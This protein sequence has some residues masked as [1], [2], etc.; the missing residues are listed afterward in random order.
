MANAT[1]VGVILLAAVLLVGVEYLA[2]ARSDPGDQGKL[3]KYA[4]PVVLFAAIGVGGFFFIYGVGATETQAQVEDPEGERVAVQLFIETGQGGVE[5][6]QSIQDDQHFGHT[7][8]NDEPGCMAVRGVEM[9]SDWTRTAEP[10]RPAERFDFRRYDDI[11]ETVHTLWGVVRRACSAIDPPR[12][13]MEV[14]RFENG[15]AQDY[16]VFDST[17]RRRLTLDSVARGPGTYEVL[18]ESR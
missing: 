13:R 9:V 2:A 8:L 15:T 12:I 4:L 17:A 18:E 11:A 5:S 16:V 6:V 1:W 14:G 7:D 3:K 10:V